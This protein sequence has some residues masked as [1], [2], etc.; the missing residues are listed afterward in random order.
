MI[1]DRGLV[2]TLGRDQARDFVK[3]GLDLSDPGGVTV[4]G[5]A[6]QAFETAALG[7]PNTVL[8]VGFLLAER[9]ATDR[10]PTVEAEA[11]HR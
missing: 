10:W 3:V 9:P 8:G 5:C 4:D 2:V 11:T 6:V 7:R 1:E